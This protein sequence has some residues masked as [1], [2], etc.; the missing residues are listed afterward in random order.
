MQNIVK[1]LRQCY[2][3]SKLPD[4]VIHGLV[5]QSAMETYRAGA[6]LFERGDVAT[7]IF[8]LLDG[9]LDVHLDT[10]AGRRITLNLL[11]PVTIFGEVAAMSSRPRTATV[12]ATRT[13]LTLRIE[14]NTLLRLLRADAELAVRA[15]EWMADN[16]AWMAESVEEAHLDVRQRLVRWL[17]RLSRRYGKP[18]TDGILIERLTQEH[19]ASMVGATREVVN[20][21]LRQLRD[22]DAVRLRRGSILVIDPAILETM[23]GR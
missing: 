6:V 9:E 3:F 16:A 23:A 1:K 14:R 13:S 10:V 22:A 5:Q 2:V 18:V 20:R 8:V 12:T 21:H 17:L 19:L 15:L 4:A 11:L 7:A